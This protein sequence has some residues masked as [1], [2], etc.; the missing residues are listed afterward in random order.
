MKKSPYEIIIVII[1]IAQLA[2]AIAS[3]LIRR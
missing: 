3:L 2:V 1:A